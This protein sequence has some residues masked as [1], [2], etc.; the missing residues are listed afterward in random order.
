MLIEQLI[1]ARAHEAPKDAQ[2]PGHQILLRGGYIQ[3]I[4][5]GIYVLLPLAQRV[6]SKV[7]AIIREEMNAI[8]G[9]EI[10]MPVVAPA[11][12]WQKS[13][14]YETVGDELVRFNDRTGRPHVLSMT[15][16]EVVVEVA[17]RQAQSYK[18]LPFMLYQIQTKFR[19]EPRSRG[20]LIRVRE[21]TMKDAYS[22]H[23]TQEDLT[24]Y[25]EICREAYKRIF[26][27]CGLREIVEIESDTGMMGGSAAHEYMLVSPVGEDTLVLCASCRYRANREVA[28]TKR[29]FQEAAA[30]EPLRDVETPG[31][32]TIEELAAFL[33]V[34]PAQ[35]MK[36]VAF[37][38]DESRPVVAFVRGDLE[39]CQTKL[40]NHLR[41]HK[42]RPMRPEE[43]ESCGAVPGYMGPVGLADTELVFDESAART[44]N[45]VTGANRPDHHW[46]GFNLA[47]DVTGKHA[48]ADIAEV[49]EGDACPQCDGTLQARRGIEVG[50]IFQLGTK[51]TK[52]MGMTYT[53]EDGAPREAIMGCYGIGIGRTMAAVVEESHD[54]H[55]PLWP[56]SIAPFE[57]EVLALGAVTGEVLEAAESLYRDLKAA[58]FDPLLDQRNVTAG[59]KLADADLIG[60]PI[61]LIVS[62]RNLANQIV[63]VKYRTCDDTSELPTQVP[64]A[65]AGESV[66]KIV[67][68]IRVKYQ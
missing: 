51:Y 19:D 13:G 34:A 33:K 60:A 56:M 23:R 14:R 66:R 6:C 39:V 3:Q 44:A 55:G 9:Q 36:A 62:K 38:A 45:L 53:E 61:R 50:N 43:F 52:T 32:K 48:L 26:R 24:R 20:G 42:L 15:H 4:G 5:Q 1:G 68:A 31:C 11:E 7:A 10:L 47:R 28:R 2:T 46:T 64:A 67:D 54:E 16:E 27:R 49:N 65:S 22:F 63:E 21:F 8:G 58:G 12:L 37:I 41:L 25:Y 30:L 17:A 57:V 59:I 29:R 40:R 18:Q 35:C